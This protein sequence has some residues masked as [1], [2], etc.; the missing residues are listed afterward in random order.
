MYFHV[1]MCVCELFEPSC[2]DALLGMHLMK[3]LLRLQMNSFIFFASTDTSFYFISDLF[4]D[5]LYACHLCSKVTVL[6]QTTFTV[7]TQQDCNN[8]SEQWRKIPT[9]KN[10]TCS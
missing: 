1:E 4:I 10:K 2:S 6:V 8:A 7:W 9:E 3:Q 5:F